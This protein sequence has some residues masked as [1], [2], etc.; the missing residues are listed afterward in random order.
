MLPS[1]AVYVVKFEH[2]F[3]FSSAD[4]T[5]SFRVR[6]E[7]KIQIRRK[8]HIRECADAAEMIVLSTKFY[9]PVEIITGHE[10]SLPNLPEVF[11]INCSH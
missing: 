9:L 7:E 6:S 11:C 5:G 8:G 1:P 2:I 4:G 3:I 10:L